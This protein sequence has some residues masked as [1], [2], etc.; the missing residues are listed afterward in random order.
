[1]K[2]I[3]CAVLLFVIVGCVDKQ[4]KPQRNL[5]LP[6]GTLELENLIQKNH[7]PQVRLKAYWKLYK[8]YRKNDQ[9]KA[10]FYLGL[11]NTLANAQNDYLNIG[12][13]LFGEAAIYKDRKD[14]L[15]ALE[16]YLESI[17]AFN[18]SNEPEKVAS[19]FNNIGAVFMETG[20]FDY[21]SDFYNKSLDIHAQSEDNL[22][23]ALANINL[24]ICSYSKKSPDYTKAKQHFLKALEKTKL[25]KKNQPFYFNKIYNCLGAM[26]FNARK[27]K[28]AQESYQKSLE[29]IAKGNQSLKL[30]AIAY[31][32]I[33]EAFM[34]EG[35]LVEA[36]AWADKVTKLVEINSLESSVAI[37]IYNFLGELK[38]HQGKLE[39][40][41]GQL[42]AA[43]DLANKDVINESLQKSLKLVNVAYKQL[44]L[45]GSQI[46]DNR[47]G[48]VVDLYENQTQLKSELI[49]KANFVSLQ[50]ALAKTIE[51][52]NERKEKEA[53]LSRK[54]L[55]SYIAWALSLFIVGGAIIYIRQSKKLKKSEGIRLDIKE[56]MREALYNLDHFEEYQRSLRK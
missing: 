19:V 23:I 34:G 42:E 38:I 10:L 32:N 33:G 46:G 3:F 54:I 30:K 9:E 31:S 11:Q 21:A 37:G 2:N 5:E 52:S 48:R 41:T 27:Y 47:Y 12:K 39:I 51:L 6:N 55:L 40:A 29:H 22:R 7:E 17:S 20:N 44:R 4:V 49:E 45:N 14:Y 28:L 24:G 15:K 13:S 16:I 50:A 25:L 35:K 1:M 8:A 43:I 36:Q 26:H 18:K 53:V 56:D